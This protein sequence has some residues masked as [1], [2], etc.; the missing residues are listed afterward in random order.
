MMADF[1]VGLGIVLIIPILASF[2]AVFSIYRE[3]NGINFAILKSS[4]KSKNVRKSFVVSTVNVLIGYCFFWGT[5]ELLLKFTNWNL[6]VIYGLALVVGLL[7][8]FSI[9]KKKDK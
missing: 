7:Q 9:A 8:P 1:F 2:C 3:H 5:K 6:F 4:F